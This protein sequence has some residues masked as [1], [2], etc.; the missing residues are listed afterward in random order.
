MMRRARL[1]IQFAELL[2][3]MSGLNKRMNMHCL[4]T[5]LIGAA[6]WCRRL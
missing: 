6:G 1:E 3:E 5:V 2:G 4:M